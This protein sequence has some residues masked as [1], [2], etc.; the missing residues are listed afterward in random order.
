MKAPKSCLLA[1]SVLFL[2][3][4]F[5]A[6]GEGTS[7]RNVLDVGCHM[8]DGTCFALLDGAP[9]GESFGCASKQ[10]R[11]SVDAHMGKHHLSMMLLA[12]KTGGTARVNLSGCYAQRNVEGVQPWPTFSYAHYR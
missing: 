3:F 5:A 11:W 2:F 9:V 10:V 6:L 4:P 7:W 8:N 1:L 12:L